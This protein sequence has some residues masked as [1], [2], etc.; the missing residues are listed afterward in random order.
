MSPDRR[1]A[2]A[3]VCARCPGGTRKLAYPWLS[4]AL[5]AAGAWC[6]C[7][8]VLPGPSLTYPLL[9]P[10]LLRLP[11]VPLLIVAPEAPWVPPWRGLCCACS[12]CCACS[13]CCVEG[14]ACSLGL[15][16]PAGGDAACSA[17]GPAEEDSTPSTLWRLSM[18][19]ESTCGTWAS[20][21]APLSLAPYEDK[22]GKTD[23]QRER[24]YPL[25][26]PSPFAWL[27]GICTTTYAPPGKRLAHCS[28]KR[29]TPHKPGGGAL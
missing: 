10:A 3:V 18:S 5:P 19:S 17:A 14:P 2:K 16:L 23:G 27:W 20:G 7:S 9:P 6:S 11:P 8:P 29:G 1:F 12:P 15:L 4:A 24:A 22:G 21:S 26:C 13:A 28:T 25:H